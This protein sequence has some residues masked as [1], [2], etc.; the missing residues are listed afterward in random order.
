MQS[1]EP[2]GPGDDREIVITAVSEAIRVLDDEG[3]IFRYREDLVRRVARLVLERMGLKED[4]AEESVDEADEQP[5]D[6]GGTVAPRRRPRIIM[7]VEDSV[8]DDLIY[9]L[10]DGV[11]RKMITRHILAKYGMT[12]PQYLEYCHLPPDYPRVAPRYSDEV[13]AKVVK[14]QGADK[15]GGEGV[16][17]KRERA[18]KRRRDTLLERPA[19][20]LTSPDQ[21]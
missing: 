8:T 9:C 1:I 21:K 17:S 13:S 18:K 19:W 11:G 7:K 12:W 10:F 6:D 16:K 2:R 15:A 20:G 3:R 4:I 14:L 5:H